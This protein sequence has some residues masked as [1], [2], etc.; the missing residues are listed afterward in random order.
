MATHF[1]QCRHRCDL[2]QERASSHPINEV[3]HQR[4]EVESEVL[5]E[6]IKIVKYVYLLKEGSR[7]Q[8]KMTPNVHCSNISIYLYDCI[9]MNSF[10]IYGIIIIPF[11]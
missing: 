2:G 4:G 5:F 7:S 8:I 6:R 9:Y 11:E 1:S 10:V 3:F